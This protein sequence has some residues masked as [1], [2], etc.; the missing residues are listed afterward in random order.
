MGLR[1]GGDGAAPAPRAPEQ[2]T[3]PPQAPNGAAA[4]VQA[5]GLPT[6][7][8]SHPINE[9]VPSQSDHAAPVDPE[10]PAGHP[11]ETS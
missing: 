4:R 1:Q 8:P 7:R 9:G 11:A 3:L 2:H 10:H 6:R 5:A